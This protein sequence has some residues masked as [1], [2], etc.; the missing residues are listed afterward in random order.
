M[1]L[2]SRALLEGADVDIPSEDVWSTL[3]A[4][5]QYYN[6][7]TSMRANV[8]SMMD[9]LRRKK[10]EEIKMLHQ[11]YGSSIHQELLNHFSSQ[12]LQQVTNAIVQRALPPSKEIVLPDIQE[13]A[14]VRKHY[15]DGVYS[16]VSNL[17]QP[18]ISI[19]N[20]NDNISFAA[21]DVSHA[22]N[23]VLASGQHIQYHRIGFEEDWEFHGQSNMQPYIQK[24]ME[25]SM[26]KQA[27][28]RVRDMLRNDPD[29]PRETRVIF[30]GGWSDAFEAHHVSPNNDFNA[31]QVITVRLKGLRDIIVPVALS[32][33]KMSDSSMVHCFLGQMKELETMEL[34]YWGSEKKL[35]PTIIIFIGMIN[36]TPEKYL[37]TGLANGGTCSMRHA[38]SC[39]YD[40]LTTPTCNN[41]LSLRK[42]IILD[43]NCSTSELPQCPHCTDWWS[44]SYKGETY[45][46]R[47][48]F[49][50]LNS[51]RDKCSSDFKVPSVELSYE[52]IEKYLHEVYDWNRLHHREKG[53][54]L[55]V[56][57]CLKLICIGYPDSIYKDLRNSSANGTPLEDTPSY[58]EIM[59]NYKK[60][61]I[62]LSMFP[63]AVMHLF[64]LGV[65]KTNLKQSKRLR[66]HAKMTATQRFWN[67]FR[68]SVKT[69]Q[70]E[71][72][73]NALTWLNNMSFNVESEDNKKLTPTGWM[74]N[75]CV[76]WMRVSL[77]Q[78][79]SLDKSRNNACPPWCIPAVHSYRRLSVLWFCICA[80][81]F[82]DC[83]ASPLEIDHLIRMFLSACHEYDVYADNSKKNSAKK[84]DIFFEKT[85]NY[86]S[87]LNIKSTLEMYGSLRHI[88]E[89][90]DEKFIKNF[91]KEIS[92]IRHQTQQMRILLKKLFNTQTL[93]ELN[94]ANPL[95]HA[96]VY[97][98]TYNCSVYQRVHDETENVSDILRN[99]YISGVVDANGDLL[100][101]FEPVRG[102]GIHL[103][104]IIFDDSSGCWLLNLWYSSCLIDPSPAFVISD[105][106]GLEVFKDHFMLLKDMESNKYT[107]ICRSWKVRVPA[108]TGLGELKLPWPQ[109]EYLNVNNVDSGN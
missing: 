57:W 26:T 13:I 20:L 3:H 103:H 6:M 35:I 22:I 81:L 1:M 15:L 43:R 89:G 34:R 5:L 7:T 84:Y 28:M 101:C 9:D 37:N 78:F 108:P 104:K 32:F 96:T 109:E 44:D 52:M 58:P 12:P 73:K 17:P 19:V 100:V 63:P 72:Q 2:V 55:V 53:A 49:N 21:I 79:R 29:L 40:K 107:A 62:G 75:H 27:H 98:R 38:F 56:A 10:D 92:V 65:T 105:R 48:S 80:N 46:I 59:K 99:D 41:C 14:Q 70:K 51:E 30:A 24:V 76:G 90:D 8:C 85:P 33:K 54:G 77:Y 106:A 91:K 39:K 88:W 94:A 97:N 47:P 64:F 11:R 16:I 50:M 31:I 95:R 4:A 68:E 71:L 82:A 102:K 60:L 18:N 86:Y 23:H 42:T 83:G 45:P 67:T 36:D 93:N 74:S 66:V 25:S 87:L 69:T 61:G